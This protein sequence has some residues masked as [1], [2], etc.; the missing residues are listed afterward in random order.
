ML[1]TKLTVT[2]VD[3]AELTPGSQA[4]VVLVCNKCARETTTTWANYVQGQRKRGWSGKT[5]C[6]KCVA[7]SSGKANR[8]KKQPSVSAANKA[9]A[10]ENHPCWKGGKYIA[11]DGYMMVAVNEA[12]E[13]GKRRRHRKE[14]HVVM[15]KLLARKLL[16]GEIIHHIDGDKINNIE[17]NLWL[18]N[19]DG[20]RAAH[21]SLQ[22]LGYKL[23]R[24]G[25]ISFVD[26]Q[27]VADLKLRELLEQPDEANQQPSRDGD[28][29]EGS[30]TRGAS[31]KDN[32]SSTSAGRRKQRR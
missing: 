25:L 18:T 23:I 1:K 19:H 28:A 6:Q 21:V 27:Y 20:H 14:H 5:F 13:S 11:N 3:V 12:K 9:R 10:G 15:E 22:A 30:E 7:S 26:G 32:K 17:T 29:S 4:S 8:G 24:S 16:P 31:F 2:G